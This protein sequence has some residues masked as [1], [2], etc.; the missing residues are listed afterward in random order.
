MNCCLADGLQHRLAAWLAH[1]Y[2]I[3]AYG[4]ETAA[5]FQTLSLWRLYGASADCTA[6]LYCLG[7][8]VWA[9]SA[10]KDFVFIGGTQ[11]HLV[12]S[13]HLIIIVKYCLHADIGY[14]V[15]CSLNNTPCFPHVQM[16]DKRTHTGYGCCSASTKNLCLFFW[17]GE[18]LI[19][20]L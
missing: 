11:L 3:W 7:A 4:S 17:V 6:E 10:E 1:L 12:R 5:D 14:Q 18:K 9:W 19:L 2:L 20:M 16:C 13:S 8:P 15:V